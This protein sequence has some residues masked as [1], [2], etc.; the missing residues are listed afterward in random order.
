MTVNFYRNVK[1]IGCFFWL[2]LYL[3]FNNRLFPSLL[4]RKLNFISWANASDSFEKPFPERSIPSKIKLTSVRSLI[5]TDSIWVALSNLKLVS[6]DW[7]FK[8]IACLTVLLCL[9]VIQKNPGHFEC[10][11]EQQN[12]K[13]RSAC[14]L[15]TLWVTLEPLKVKALQIEIHEYSMRCHGYQ[16]FNIHIFKFTS[17]KNC[18]RAS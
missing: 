15:T 13:T 14:C 12:Q 17:H 8:S 1:A 3:L 4:K 10:Y 5:G 6:V 9:P 18:A 11:F 7:H 16:H 2:V